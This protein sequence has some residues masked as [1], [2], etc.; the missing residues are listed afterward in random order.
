LIPGIEP[1][2]VEK[3][4]VAVNSYYAQFE[5]QPATPVEVVTED[6]GEPEAAAEPEETAGVAVGA[7]LGVAQEAES[8]AESG[9]DS[10]AS[11][12]EFDNIRD[13]GEVS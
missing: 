7:A 1:D 2:I 8:P 13:S 10:S 11:K 6:V 3:I 9:E 5:Q 12:K 4:L